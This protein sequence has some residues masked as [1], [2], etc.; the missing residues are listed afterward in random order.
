M[1]IKGHLKLKQSQI[2]DVLQQREKLGSAR[3]GDGVAILHGKI[4]DLEKLI[5]AF[6]SIDGKTVYLW[7]RTIFRP[8]A[9][10]MKIC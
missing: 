3:I 10:L 1:V 6:D 8:L 2:F 7:F 5:V 9:F 4:D